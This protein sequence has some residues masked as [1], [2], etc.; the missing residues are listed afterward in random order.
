MSQVGA[1]VG[2]WLTAGLL[3]WLALEAGPTGARGDAMPHTH[4]QHS[5]KQNRHHS[6]T[7]GS[8]RDRT[9]KDPQGPG[10]QRPLTFSGS[11]QFT[12]TVTFAPPL[13]LTPQPV[14]QYARASG[15]CSGTLIDKQGQ[16]HNLNN[17]PVTYAA[18]EQG[19]SISC[20]E[21]TDAGQGTLGFEFGQ[22][23][24]T[25]SEDRV[26]PIANLSFKGAKAGT[27]SGSATAS[28][29]PAT[30]AMECAGSGLKQASASLNMSTDSP[31]SG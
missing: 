19:N 26:G 27:A 21:G 17:T 3:V 1:R 23:R 14:T 16:T 31:L 9:H 8:R 11:C 25:I 30:I 2:R 4:D 12:G 28:G 7:A 20:G 29:D 22:L 13:V 15:N 6:H 24:F 10:D 18:T 5:H